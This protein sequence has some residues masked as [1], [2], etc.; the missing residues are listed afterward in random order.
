L[1]LKQKN[2]HDSQ[3]RSMID[4]VIERFSCTLDVKPSRAHGAFGRLE[5]LKTGEPI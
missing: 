2:R 1:S 4:L 3:D 5:K